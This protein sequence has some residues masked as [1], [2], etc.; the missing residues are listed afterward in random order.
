MLCARPQGTSGYVDARY[1]FLEGGWD[2]EDGTQ[3]LR[4]PTHSER[5][6]ERVKRGEVKGGGGA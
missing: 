4:P 2:Q 6:V 3:S 1:V 5:I